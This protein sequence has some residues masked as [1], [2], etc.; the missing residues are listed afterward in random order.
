MSVPNLSVKAAVTL[1]GVL[2][3]HFYHKFCLL[4]CEY[5]VVSDGVSF[6]LG[7]QSL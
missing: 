2:S 3:L 7:Q 1:I 4:S 6:S 5:T